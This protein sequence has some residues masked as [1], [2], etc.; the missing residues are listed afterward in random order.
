MEEVKYTLIFNKLEECKK[1]RKH[2]KLRKSRQWESRIHTRNRKQS[3]FSKCQKV[4]ENK[5]EIRT[6]KPFNSIKGFLNL[7]T[8][9]I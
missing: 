1:M 7:S 9:D 3:K 2:S 6:W 5:V 8:L 4:V